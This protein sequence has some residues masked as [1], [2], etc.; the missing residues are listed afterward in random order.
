MAIVLENV[1]FTHS[2]KT[3]FEKTAVKNCSITINEG[4]F[5]AVV[6]RTG[7]GKTT[8]TQIL[9]GLNIVPK[10]SGKVYID[11]E[12]LTKKN[13]ME[14]R[15][16]IGY[17]FQ[18]P[19]H[20]LFEETVYK[21]IAFGLKRLKLSE[22]EEDRRIRET[23]KLVGLSEELLERS[24]YELSGGEKRRAAIC[25]VLVSDPKYIIFDEPAAGLD[26]AGKNYILG[27]MKRM[28]EAGKTI[29]LISHSM[30]DVC[31]FAKR[32]VVMHNAEIKFDGK[33][34]EV[35]SHYDELV[36][37]GLDVPEIT[38]LFIKLNEKYPFVNKNVFNLSE[39]EAEIKR[40]KV[41]GRLPKI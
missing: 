15:R 12:L 8:L 22:E 17:V 40:L 31:E 30:D 4:E 2:I 16:K 7:C 26:P 20:Q 18:Y 19:E 39:A 33:N 41:E 38:K 6:G 13:A 35:F 28:N 3:P 37:F 5:I 9:N 24:V 10:N 27:L 23:I 32:T 21:D 14:L 29:I 34:E 11:G 36:S 25:G 1:T